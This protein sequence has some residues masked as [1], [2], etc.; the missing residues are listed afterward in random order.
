MTDRD[1]LKFAARAAGYVVEFIGDDAYRN[2]Q[3]GRWDPLEDDGDAFRLAVDLKLEL[4]LG[5][6]A[7]VTEKDN[8]ETRIE[9]VW[10]ENDPHA[11]RRA[12]VMTAAEIGKIQND[13]IHEKNKQRC[14]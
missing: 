12:I 8:H 7:V 4:L 3:M 14:T 11:L 6:N 1:L 13:L 9:F 2:G 5:S 10:H